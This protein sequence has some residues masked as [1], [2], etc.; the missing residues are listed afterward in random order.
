MRLTANTHVA[1]YNLFFDLGGR[2][3]IWKLRFENGRADTYFLAPA[4]AVHFT[5]AARRAA[6]KHKWPSSEDRP[7]DIPVIT[8]EERDFLNNQYGMVIGERVIAFS[9]ALVCAFDFG[10]GLLQALRFSPKRPCRL[11]RSIGS[12]CKVAP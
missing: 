8:E 4:V 11:H 2:T 9:D 7:D 12:K 1:S 6:R 10:K 5:K 3:V